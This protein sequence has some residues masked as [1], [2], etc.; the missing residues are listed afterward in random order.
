MEF[1]NLTTHN[2]VVRTKTEERLIPPSGQIARAVIETHPWTIISRIPVVRTFFGAVTGLPEPKSGV[3]YIT[4][5]IVAQAA[6]RKDVLAPDT[7]PTAIRDE[8]GQIIAV[9]QL[10]WPVGPEKEAK[11]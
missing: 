7:G 2:V 5:T 9:T 10:Q 1:I 3:T 11:L 4:S 6:R 8:L